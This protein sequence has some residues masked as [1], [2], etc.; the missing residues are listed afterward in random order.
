MKYKHILPKN[1][2]QKAEYVALLNAVKKYEERIREIES[3]SYWKIFLFLSKTKLVLTSESYLKS[4]NW[5]FF[6]R[7]KFLISKP[8]FLLIS[9]FL[10]Q[11]FLLLFGKVNF[12]IGLNKG[13]EKVNYKLYKEK[14]FPRESDLESKFLNISNLKLNPHIQIFVIVNSENFVFLNSFLNSIEKQ[15]YDH[16]FVHFIYL[17]NDKKILYILKNIVKNDVRYSLH[18][19]DLKLE[20]ICEYGLFTKVNCI[21]RDDCLYEFVNEINNNHTAGI[22]YSDNDRRDY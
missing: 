6:Q 3:S 17:E 12:I 16:F 18:Q 10:R 20:L 8:G 7:I 13:F 4:N 22:I 15:V 19:N 14:N 1:S 2:F 11:L 21:L 9:K 5:I